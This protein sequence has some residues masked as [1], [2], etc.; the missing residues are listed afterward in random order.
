MARASN[1]TFIWQQWA[2]EYRAAICERLN[3]EAMGFSNETPL[4]HPLRASWWD[5][6][7]MALNL[8]AFQ[9]E[10]AWSCACD[11]NDIRLAPRWPT[12][13][14]SLHSSYRKA[15]KAAILLRKEL[16]AAAEEPKPQRLYT[17]IVCRHLFVDGN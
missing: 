5:S 2:C 9:G 8:E 1:K 11:T 10:F 14:L 4:K 7:C 15:G 12:F 6:D 17:N 3:F 16:G 13:H